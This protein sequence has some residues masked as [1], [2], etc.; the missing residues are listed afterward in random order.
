MPRVDE[1]Q[2]D[3]QTYGNAPGWSPG[4]APKG[5]EA[6]EGDSPSPD[7]S[8]ASSAESDSQTQPSEQAPP[9]S[10]QPAAEKEFHLPPKERWEERQREIEALRVQNQQLLDLAQR[11]TQPATTPQPVGDPWEG[12]VNHPDPATAQFYQQQ[13][14]LMEFERQR[15]RQEAVQELAPVIDAGRSEIARLNTER[16]REKHPDIKPGSEEERLIVSY[17]S[18]QV[19]GMRHP[20]E[21]AKR[22]AMYDRLE[23]ENQALKS[24]Q[25]SVPQKRAAANAE[26]SPGIPQTA[27]LPPKPGDW[28]AR[29]S[30]V[31]DR[32]GSFIDAANAIF[33]GPRR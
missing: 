9:P 16:F 13:R 1:E 12:L 21:S 24:K 23:A 29:V 6:Q 7:A 11:T 8:S 15:A 31:V 22:N 4:A 2:E 17:M 5:T 26:V 27:G 10:S 25:A 33:G 19:D 3:R 18:G 30:E 20:L 14:K 28:R 32:G